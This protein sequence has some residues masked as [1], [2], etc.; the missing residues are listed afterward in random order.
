M[1]RRLLCF[2]LAGFFALSVLLL[3]HPPAVA[4]ASPHALTVYLAADPHYI[5]PDLTDNGSGFTSLVEAADGKD[6]LRCEA[7]IDAFLARIVQDRPDA[8]ILL[9]DLSFN[10][11][12]ASL[13]RF[14]EKLSAVCE[15]GIPVFVIPGNH[16]LD[17]PMAARFS[18]DT[19]TLVPSV[20]AAGFA[21][22]YAEYG[23]RGALSRDSA[24]LSYTARLSSDF[25]LLMLDVN[26]NDNPGSVSEATLRW[27][28]QQLQQANADGLDVIAVSHQTL[29]PHSFLTSGVVIRNAEPLLSLYEQYHVCCNLSGHMHIQHIL[30]S[31]NGFPEISGSALI[32]WP[33]QFGVLT[34]TGDRFHYR[35]EQTETGVE[36]ESRQFLRE[37][38]IRQ[39]VTELQALRAKTDFPSMA[40]YF[41]RVNMAYISGRLDQ[42][43]WD[44]PC[45]ETW[46]AQQSIVAY[47]LRTIRD[48]PISDHTVFD[49]PIP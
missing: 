21:E 16:D 14:A 30:V 36:E 48:D 38:A 45:Y 33:N 15:A 37:T 25:L 11:A 12:A 31:P 3:I 13:Q 44:D 39:A 41:A 1:K 20:S 24:S 43:D 22:L 27:V 4:E 19:Y 28:E 32:T 42:I 23:Y 47:Y 9:G 26:G 6:M 7:I 34:L 5:A 18:G 35:T 17:Y 10:G 40:D 8:L 29:L 2:L 46:Q 49:N